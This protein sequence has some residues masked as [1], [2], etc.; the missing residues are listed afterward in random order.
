[1]TE[2][3]TASWAWII[4]L[5][6]VTPITTF[7]HELAHAFSAHYFTGQPVTIRM[8]IFSAPFTK[9]QWG[10][11][12][13]EIG[14]PWVSGKVYGEA[15]QP[16]TPF[17]RMI[18]AGVAPLTSL[19]ILVLMSVL[20]YTSRQGDFLWKM[21]TQ[22]SATF[23]FIE[24]LLTAIPMR[25]P[26]WFPGHGGNTSD[27]YKVLENWKLYRAQTNIKPSLKS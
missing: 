5:F 20:A 14:F 2:F 21:F 6:I 9:L 23:V 26:K 16:L 24:V 18:S 10:W 22:Y 3:S 13:I 15:W 11:L 12:Q 1:M 7:L 17:Q 19:G 25:Y 4:T 8:G 27:G